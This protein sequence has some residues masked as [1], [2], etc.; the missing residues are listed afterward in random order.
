MPDS[1]ADIL[2]RIFP[3]DD[4]AGHYPVEAELDDGSRF[5]D[6][7]LKL[8]HA[9]LLA[10]QFDSEAYG[11]TLFNALFAGGGDIRRA[12][13]KATGKAE[14]N[15]GGR[16]RVRVWVDEGAVELHAI[17]WERLYHLH[18]GRP[19]PLGASALTP[20]S[21]YT[22]LEIREPLPITETPIRVLVAVSNPTHLPGGLAPANVDLEIENLRRALAELRRQDQVHVTVMP[23]H[24]GLSPALRAR[25]EGEGYAIV[26][27]VTNLFNIAPHLTRC[28]VFHF[29]GHGAFRKSVEDR[30]T[31]T[32]AL[33]LEKADGTWQATK[34]EE[35]ASMFTVLGTL[36]HLVFLVACESAKREAQ[37]TSPFVGLGPKLVRAGV[38]A[39]VAMQE[40][41]PVEMA[42]TLA[43]EFYAR[44]AEHGEVDRALNQAR[45]QIFNSRSIEW[46]IPVLFMRIRKGRLFGADPDADAP[47]PGEA[48]FKGLEY[49]NEND[50]RKFYGRELLTA[51]LVGK[52]R[53]SRFLPVIVGASGSGKSSVVRAGLIP[54]LKR[55]EALADGTLPPEGSRTWVTHVFTPGAH[56]LEALAVNLTRDAESMSATTHLL[57]DLRMDE[58]ALHF[59][60]RKRLGE[61]PGA[62]RL[63]VIVDQFEEIFTLCKDDD[64]RRAFIN[65]LL[66]ASSEKT[67]GPT[68]VII[69]FRADFYAHC[70]QYANLRAA[71]STHQE[72]VGPMI[73]DELRRAIEEPA[74]AGGWDF[75]PGLVDLILK[76]VGDEPGA[77]PLMQHALLE[78]WK[79]RRARTMTLRGYNDAGGIRGAIARTAEAI[80][81]QLPAEQQAMAKRIFLRLVELGEGT[82]DTRRRALLEELSPNA[83]DQPLIDLVLK[84][85]TDNRLVV[86]TATTVEVAHEALIREWPT[87]REWINQNREALRVHRDLGEG[88]R[89]WDNLMR[90]S[91]V[92]YR[93][94]KLVQALEWAEENATEMNELEAEFLAASRAEAEREAREKD[95]R[96]QRELAAAKKLAEEQARV[97]EAAQK[98]AEAEKQRAAERAEADRKQLEAT[99]KLAEAGRQQAAQRAEADQK[100]LASA[101]RSRRTFLIFGLLAGALAIV[102]FIAFGVAADA[103]NKAYIA[104]T[105]A[106]AQENIAVTERANADAQ[107]AIANVASTQAVAQQSIAEAAST[108][109]VAERAKA[110]EERQR[111]L[112]RQLAAQAVAQAGER[113]DLAFLLSVEG[114][115]V[116]DTLEARDALLRALTISPRVLGYRWG[117]PKSVQAFA[118]APDDQTLVVVADGNKVQVWN[119]AEAYDLRLLSVVLELDEPNPF[120]AALSIVLYPDGQ[121][122]IVSRCR[123][124]SDVFACFESEL[125]F[126]DL[127][128]PASPQAIGEPLLI[129]DIEIEGLILGVNGRLLATVYSS[130]VVQLW[131]VGDPKAPQALGESFHHSNES[132]AQEIEVALSL[133]EPLLATAACV[134]Y[135]DDELRCY[136]TELRLWDVSNPRAPGLI[137][138][139]VTAGLDTLSTL[140]FSPRN[141]ELVMNGLRQFQLWDLNDWSA[142]VPLGDPLDNQVALALSPSGE[143]LVTTGPDNALQLWNITRNVPQPLGP[144]LRGH[145]AHVSG[146]TFTADG[147]TLLSAGG[148]QQMV[149]WDVTDPAITPLLGTRIRLSDDERS[150]ST[151]FHPNGAVMAQGSDQSRVHLWNVG[152]PSAP[153]LIGQPFEAGLDWVLNLAFNSNGNLLV[154]SGQGHFRLWDVSDLTAPIR[155]G[156]LPLNPNDRNG[157][158]AFSPV[159]EV[160]AVSIPGFGLQFWGVDDP[161]TPQLLGEAQDATAAEARKLFF[162]ADG[163]LL[164]VFGS[165]FT[166]WEVSD[167]AAP[168]LLGTLVVGNFLDSAAFDSA[169]S[170]VATL[171]SEGLDSGLRL[172][173]VSDPASPR[174]VG[175]LL[176]GENI[177]SVAIVPDVALSPD[178]RTMVIGGEATVQLWDVNDPTNPRSIGTPLAKVGFN[179]LFSP[180][181]RLLLS[182]DFESDIL[183]PVSP[184]LWLERACALVG[185]NFTQAEWRRYLNEV[186]YRKTCAQWPVGE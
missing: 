184:E 124:R 168:R 167:W 171:N 67:D 35:I 109:A 151:A 51:R 30:G 49:F 21:R 126:W 63:L 150:F 125:Q 84:K 139:G 3:F 181:G 60:A 36:P 159:D 143:M 111:A 77:L 176:Q 154:T 13:D 50:A 94:V 78:T 103:S 115:Q 62:N 76:E 129:P 8:D 29:I 15:T 158:P 136:T 7:R 179:F 155:R 152:D 41:A 149:F 83:A 102:S 47:A 117:L 107:A 169:R 59:H 45:A 101:H 71:V 46:A 105:Q 92:L 19:T 174:L 89:E 40:Q 26:D 72:F 127:S 133:D 18:K 177:S 142:P 16:L 172:W 141:A 153:T 106:V 12:Y 145:V 27:G 135:N 180:D 116:E 183:W 132:V 91:G 79:R 110:E 120:A 48:P 22:S 128:N 66:Y 24:T 44:L 9:A 160:L 100:Q 37:A 82:Q 75:E 122:L 65:S 138:A 81:A 58:R 32:A 10:Q 56:P 53:L 185:R 97:A 11:L 88:A 157:V 112:G 74:K 161:N 118:L 42:R 98:L 39:V 55:G 182:N 165:N 17:P 25:L 175:T 113:P 69:I 119:V 20:L 95:E 147:Q 34:D 87:F 114:Y 1:Y 14:A 166:L 6:G 68:V 148:G 43:G 86:T 4:V 121:T 156:D 80:Y 52:L 170:L 70:A 186:P 131:E 5:T 2:L 140:F 146:A 163:K 130:Q 144:P 61:R 85:L 28:H 99:Q 57:E 108:Q 173:D 162:S 73:K 123:Q 23:G 31:G 38:P 64:E 93:G 90:E 54:A 96:Q 33:Y 134:D 104:S 178:E 137:G 164:G